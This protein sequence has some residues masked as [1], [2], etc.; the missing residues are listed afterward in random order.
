MEQKNS[1]A[2]RRLAVVGMLAAMVFIFTYIGIDIPSPLGKAKVHMG[3]VMCLLSGLLFGGVPGGLAAG[4][5]SGLFD[6]MDPAWAPE[7]WITAINKFAMAFVAGTLAKK[8]PLNRHAGYWVAG[9]AGAVSYC[10]LYVSKNILSGHFIKGFA[11]NVAI[12]E[13]VTVKL[14]VTLVNALIAVVCSVLLAEALRPALQ[15]A[16]LFR[17]ALT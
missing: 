4:I 5:G 6:L 11:W 12:L 17:G 15:R 13:T 3:N 8:L 16:G 14:P 9:V 2:V 1:L 7:F 10:V